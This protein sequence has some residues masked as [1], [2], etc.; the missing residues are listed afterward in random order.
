MKISDT[1]EFGFIDRLASSFKGLLK[2]GITG[3]GDDCAVIPKNETESY[4]VTTDMLVEDVHFLR[5]R[6]SPI[7]PGVQVAGR[8]SQ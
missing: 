4:V 1:G 5:D 6:I 8:Q 3:I 7:R 2:D